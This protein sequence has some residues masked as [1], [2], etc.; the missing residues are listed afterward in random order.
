MAEPKVGML[1]ALLTTFI[2]TIATITTILQ[3]DETKEGYKIK[4]LKAKQLSSSPA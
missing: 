4:Q 1:H 2:T 3:P